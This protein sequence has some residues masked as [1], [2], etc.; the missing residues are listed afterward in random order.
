MATDY[1]NP[2]TTDTATEHDHS[3]ETLKARRAETT[4]DLGDDT[5][6]LEAEFDLPGTDPSGEDLLIRVLPPQVDE[7][8]CTSCFLV[9]HRSQLADQGRG[10]CRECTA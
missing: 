7:F 6:P 9:Q 2:R 4:A 8:T 10:V 3:L 1:D 5:D